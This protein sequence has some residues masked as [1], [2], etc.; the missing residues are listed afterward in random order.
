MTYTPKSAVLL[1]V[2]CVTAIASVGSIFEL[3]SGEP[4]LGMTLTAVILGASLPL[5]GLCL[6]FAV[7]AA[8]E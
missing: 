2:S 7:K 5:T 6:F 3:S 4:Q 1:L 8:G